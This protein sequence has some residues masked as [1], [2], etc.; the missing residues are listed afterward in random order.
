MAGYLTGGI[1]QSDQGQPLLLR[2]NHISSAVYS[3]DSEYLSKA[4]KNKFLFFIR[5]VKSNGTTSI[6]TQTSSDKLELSILQNTLSSKISQYSRENAEGFYCKNIDRPSV[7]YQTKTLDQ[8][9]KKR[10]IQTGVRYNPIRV[11]FNDTANGVA[12]TLAKDYYKFYYGDPNNTSVNAWADDIISAQMNA[13][14]G[15]WGFTL[16]STTNVDQLNYFSSIQI[17]IFYNGFYDQYDL[18]NPKINDFRSDNLDYSATNGILSIDLNISYEGIVYTK[19]KV[20]VLGD[21]SQIETF[22]FDM[23]DFYQPANMSV[24]DYGLYFAPQVSFENQYLDQ[25]YSSNMFSLSNII[26][27]VSTIIHGDSFMLQ[28]YQGVF[29]NTELGEFIHQN[30]GTLEQVYGNTVGTSPTARTI[31]TL[32]GIF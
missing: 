28:G 32:G 20:H 18:V 6:T 27:D 4:P 22:G 7:V 16:P 24:T 31:A 1:Q 13:G 25:T 3:F 15:S 23:G 11:S 9:N 26:S 21:T 29:A 17:F 5:F 14:N 10:I 8:Y 19:N 12:E 30:R 2:D